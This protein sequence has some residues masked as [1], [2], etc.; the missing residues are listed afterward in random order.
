M[1]LRGT[2]EGHILKTTSGG[3]SCSSVANG[4]PHFSLSLQHSTLQ[5][6]TNEERSRSRLLVCC[7]LRQAQ[8]DWSRGLSGS[9]RLRAGDALRNWLRA[10]AARTAATS[11]DVGRRGVEPELV[12]AA[13]RV[14]TSRLQRFVLING[15]RFRVISRKASL[16]SPSVSDRKV[17]ALYNLLDATLEG[18]LRIDTHRGQQAMGAR[19]TRAVPQSFAP[20]CLCRVILLRKLWQT[21]SS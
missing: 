2:L 14:A 7:L 9:A 8:K 13:R 20:F 17:R 15:T 10:L 5:P 6:S 3:K 21:C 19:R 1:G 4:G 16:A 12:V 18:A 11:G